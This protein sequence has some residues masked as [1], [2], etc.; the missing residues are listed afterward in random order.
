LN[1][2]RI[3]L[4]NGDIWWLGC[5]NINNMLEIP[6]TE[7]RL[8]RLAALASED[9]TA[10]PRLSLGYLQAINSSCKP[11]CNKV[12][13]YR[14]SEPQQTARKAIFTNRLATKFQS[15]GCPNPSEI[16][17]PAPSAA[18]SSLRPA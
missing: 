11:L 6:Q 2:E 14:L 18:D 16:W 1:L 4:K 5:S 15:T 7:L 8:L 3:N 17:Q 10:Y 9:P 12:S 13:K